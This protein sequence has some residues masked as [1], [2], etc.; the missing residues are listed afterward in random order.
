MTKPQM[1][2]GIPASVG[3]NI[4]DLRLAKGFSLKTFYKAGG[5]TQSTMSAIENAKN[6]F[7][8]GTLIQ[9]A[10]VLGVYPS[11]LLP[12]ELF[13]EPQTPTKPG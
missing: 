4:R 8:V 7:D 2:I 10:K 13:D 11:A 5:P 9:I 1:P 12:D 6:G 3:A